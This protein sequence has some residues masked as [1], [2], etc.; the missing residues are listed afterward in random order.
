MTAMNPVE[1]DRPYGEFQLTDRPFSVFARLKLSPGSNACVSISTAPTE[2]VRASKV[3]KLK[4]RIMFTSSCNWEGQSTTS[5]FQIAGGLIKQTNG[6]LS[7][8]GIEC[9]ERT[10]HDVIGSISTPASLA[11]CTMH[12]LEIMLSVA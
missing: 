6:E 4:H 8:T 3:K 12:V 7:C 10:V 9:H 5:D 2:A 1:K 11:H